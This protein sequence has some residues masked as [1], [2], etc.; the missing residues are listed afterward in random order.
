MSTKDNVL[1]P[2][3]AVLEEKK[4]ETQDIYT[5]KFKMMDNGTISFGPGQY[6]M[7]GVPRLGESAISFSTLPIGYNGFVHTI[8]MAGNVTRAICNMNVGDTV[9]VRGPY[10]NIWPLEKAE[11]KN[12]VI[13][14]GGIG[15]APLRPVV[16]TLLKNKKKY[17]KLFLVYGSKE[18]DIIMYKDELEAWDRSGNIKVLLSVDEEPNSCFLNLCKGLVTTLLD[19]IDVPLSESVSYVCGSEVMMH[20][21]ALELMQKG[22]KAKDIFVSMERR[23][24]CGVAHCGHCQV[25]AKFVCK[26][27]AVFN[28][29]EI[30]KYADNVL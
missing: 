28:Y 12:V 20:Y 1:V 16:Y 26:D 5:L 21:V 29:Q 27:G 25:G 15:M 9:L 11:K 24:K 8:R 23:M 17:K 6:N 22:Q 7:L 18:E 19:K 10:G 30:K 3:V 2:R 4:L 13:V 14:A